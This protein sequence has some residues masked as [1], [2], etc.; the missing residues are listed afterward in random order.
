MNVA[1]RRYTSEPGIA[2]EL[3]SAI[4][5]H[6]LPD[7]SGLPGFVA[8]YAVDCGDGDIV[9]ISVF[10]SPE[11]EQR[12]MRMAQDFVKKYFPDR[13]SRMGYD[14]GLCFVERHA[15]VPA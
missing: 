6:F 1:I 12:S 8:Y 9:T 11:S 7:I 4:E 2:V 13:I 3:K 15:P 10:E 5:E 14:E